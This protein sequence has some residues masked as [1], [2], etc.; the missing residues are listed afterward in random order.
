INDS[1]VVFDRIRENLS[2]E[3]NKNIERK[4]P[5]IVNRS[6]NETMVRSINTS[7]TT[8]LAIGA[9]FFVGGVALRYLL[10]TLSMGI[11]LGTYSSLFIASPILVVWLNKKYKK[12]KI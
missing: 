3:K 7:L 4:Y 6:L 10:L 1:V 5:E 11:I 12:L 9:I 8:L 2:L